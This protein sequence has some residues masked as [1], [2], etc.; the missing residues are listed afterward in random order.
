LEEKL[1][2]IEEEI[3]EIEINASKDPSLLKWTCR[4]ITVDKL[5]KRNILREVTYETCKFR[6]YMEY[7]KEYYSENLRNLVKR[8]VDKNWNEKEIPTMDVMSFWYLEDEILAKIETQINHSYLVFDK[9]F[10]EFSAFEWNYY[11]HEMLS[12][13]KVNFIVLR[14]KLH[15]VLTPMNQLVYKISNV[16]KLQ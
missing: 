1:K 6:V 7:L 16:M 2:K 13:L 3:A 9:A 5:F 15:N 11:I 12:L 8:G 14:I 4:Q 10:K